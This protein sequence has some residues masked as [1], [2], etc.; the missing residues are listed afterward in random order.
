M[1]PHPPLPPDDDFVLSPST[2]E[3]IHL[4][5]GEEEAGVIKNFE[6]GRLFWISAVDQ[7]TNMAPYRRETG[8][9]RQRK[10]DWGCWNA[11]FGGGANIQ[12]LQPPGDRCFPVALTRSTSLLMHFALLSSITEDNKFVFF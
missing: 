1:C 9:P 6:I 11:G 4:N 8:S 5:C 7:D 10:G 12:G 2:W 3:H